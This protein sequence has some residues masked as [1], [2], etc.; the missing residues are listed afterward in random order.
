MKKTSIP[1]CL[2]ILSLAI[3]SCSVRPATDPPVVKE[4]ASSSA[5]LET[6]LGEALNLVTGTQSRPSV[7]P[8]YH[9]EVRLNMP[10]LSEA[11]KS[12]IVKARKL[13]ADVQ[14]RNIHVFYNYQSDPTM[15][16]YLIGDQEYQVTDGKPQEVGVSPISTRWA[17]WPLDVVAIFAPSAIISQKSGAD[18]LEGRPAD[19]YTADTVA[20]PIQLQTLNTI[21]TTLKLFKGTIWIDKQTGGLLQ[22]SMDYQMDISSLDGSMIVGTGDGHLE[23]AISKIG[24]ATVSLP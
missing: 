2:L 1:A 12:V 3:M 17:M 15:E 22:T 7:Y 24:Q 9:I 6:N 23:L 4:P 8:S 14:G 18:E 16:G 21:G 5:P 13:T 20:N 11:G 19:V 10:A